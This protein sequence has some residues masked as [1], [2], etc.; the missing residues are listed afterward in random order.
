[1]KNFIRKIEETDSRIKML[2]LV[3]VAY[4]AIAFGFN[5]VEAMTKIEN[6]T[7][8]IN[9][10]IK[11]GTNE[12]V[13]HLV[14]QATVQDVLNE[15]EIT[16]GSEDFVNLDATTLLDD[17]QTIEINRITYSE[18][19]EEEEIPFTTEITGDDVDGATVDVLQVGENGALEN[20]YK[21]RM[22]NAIEVSRELIN[23]IVIKEAINQVE[24]YTYTAPVQT[25]IVPESTSSSAFTGRLTTYGGDCVGCSGITAAGVVLNE[26]GANNSGSAKVNY[27]G[28]W[29]YVLAADRSIPFGTIIE[30]SNHNLSLEP[31]IYGV[32]L[33]RGGDI[34]GGKI[35][36]FSG[37]ERGARFFTGG[38]SYNTQFRIVG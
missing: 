28:G 25:T 20:T 29:Y 9:I 14:K 31:V 5:H 12:P 4:V 11:D 36:I 19:K 15:L 18:V 1:M 30:I 3:A 26:N 10:S 6:Y 7:P 8:A 16:L 35:D 33:D 21:V 13:G 17:D 38:T 23:Q 22:Q 24:N 2:L 34:T 27:N 37:S 32:V